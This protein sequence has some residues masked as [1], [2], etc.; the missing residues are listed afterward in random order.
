LILKFFLH[1]SKEEQRRRFLKR[2]DHPSKYWKFSAGDL[3][4][5]LL[6]DDYMKAYEEALSKTSAPYAPW[7]IV[8][9]DHKWF[10]RVTIAELVIDAI[11]AVRLEFPKPAK[12]QLEE[13]ARARKRLIAER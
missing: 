11:E 10:T 3:D 6:W 13:L 4:E 8:P 2:L 1:M 9:A 5:R 7:F 12:A